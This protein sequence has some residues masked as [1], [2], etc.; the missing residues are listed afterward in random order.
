M[1]V[2]I[3]PK[4]FSIKEVLFQIK[5]YV[6]AFLGFLLLVS[7]VM[8]RL[9]PALPTYAKEYNYLYSMGAAM[10]KGREISIEKFDEKLLSFSKLRPEFD[11]FFAEN[12]IV[13][14][15]FEKVELLM[16]SVRN[17]LP[18]KNEVTE[19]FTRASVELEKNNYKES[20]AYA[21]KLK[22]HAVCKES[23]PLIFAY[24][25]YR[26]LVLEE[27]L[28]YKELSFDTKDTLVHFIKEDKCSKFSQNIIMKKILKLLE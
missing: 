12:Y 21:L 16:E 13:N 14:K 10:E 3:T 15:E 27:I 28:G 17:R 6:L 26:V 18:I 9:H 25:L 23:F 24:N 4:E 5:Y 2:E 22:D 19:S 8:S 1:K 20:Y 7:Y 11:G